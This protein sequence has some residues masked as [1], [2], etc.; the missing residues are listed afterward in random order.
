MGKNNAEIVIFK[1]EN[2]TDE[3]GNRAFGLKFVYGS[4]L[5]GKVLLSE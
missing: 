1:D 2:R 5:E 3:K 4:G